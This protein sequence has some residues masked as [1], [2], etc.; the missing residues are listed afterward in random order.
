MYF[1]LFLLIYLVSCKPLNCS[2]HIS[3]ESNNNDLNN[4]STRLICNHKY[5]ISNLKQDILWSKYHYNLIGPVKD[6]NINWQEYIIPQMEH[7]CKMC[8]ENHALNQLYYTSPDYYI[9]TRAY[10]PLLDWDP[11]GYQHDYEV[12]NGFYDPEHEVDEQSFAKYIL[13]EFTISDAKAKHTTTSTFQHC[14]TTTHGDGEGKPIIQI[15]KPSLG[16]IECPDVISELEMNQVFL[17][18]FCDSNPQNAEN[19]MIR[20]DQNILAHNVHPTYNRSFSLS[21][22]NKTNTYSIQRTQLMPPFINDFSVNE[23]IMTTDRNIF[24][25]KNMCILSKIKQT[26]SA[27]TTTNAIRWMI[28]FILFR[29]K[30]LF[31]LI[32]LGLITTNAYE[33]P[34][35]DIGTSRDKFGYGVGIENDKAII[36]AP[37]LGAAYYFKYDSAS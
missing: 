22:Q 36:G 23:N 33:M 3:A 4:P 29:K 34:K 24:L 9:T 20:N 31:P 25:S 15:Q 32:L 1:F 30:T 27:I 10:T 17:P 28:G 21:F 5:M 14:K 26:V 18:G 7:D 8:D 12:Y 37:G 35:L 19:V 13:C 16:A 2:K 11:K 6:D